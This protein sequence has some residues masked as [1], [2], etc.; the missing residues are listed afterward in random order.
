MHRLTRH[1]ALLLEAEETT[2]PI[3]DKLV[4]DVEELAGLGRLID[5]EIQ[6]DAMIPLLRL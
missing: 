2:M 4:E 3:L 1:L 5:P 6:D